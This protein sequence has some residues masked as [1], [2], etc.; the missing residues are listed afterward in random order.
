ML[1]GSSPVDAGVIGSGVSTSCDAIHAAG[2]FSGACPG[3]AACRAG[4]G[5]VA[6]ACT[7]SSLDEATRTNGACLV[8]ARDTTDAWLFSAPSGG[9]EAPV[10]RGAEGATKLLPVLLLLA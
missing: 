2:V 9:G 8:G 10:I 7:K 6:P 1:G 3:G 5:E 4:K